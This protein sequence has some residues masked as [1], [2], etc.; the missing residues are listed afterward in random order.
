MDNVCTF[1]WNVKK[2]SSIPWPNWDFGFSIHW[3][4]GRAGI[5]NICSLVPR[6]DICS[7]V[8]RRVWTV[9]KSMAICCRFSSMVLSHSL[10]EIVIKS[11]EN[12]YQDCVK[13]QKWFGKSHAMVTS[14]KEKM[15]FFCLSHKCRH[16]L[17]LTSWHFC[18]DACNKTNM[19]WNSRH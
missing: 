3:N 17:L 11:E 14:I 12:H 6:R 5:L 19:H 8:T 4:I 10:F 16:L 15:G 1:W 7:L 2:L 9:K 18:H 13:I